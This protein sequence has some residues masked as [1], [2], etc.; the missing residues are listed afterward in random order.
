MRRPAYLAAGLVALALGFIGIFLPLLPTTP[1]V[2]LAAFCFARGNPAWEARLLADP[3]FG[4]SIRAWRER[5]AIPRNGKRLAVLM[6]L[7]SA[8]G[9]WFLLTPPWHVVPA[10]VCLVVG[11]WVLT[12]PSA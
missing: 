7:I 10:G 3:R 9:G 12:R 4:P 11:A 6:M 2:L 5:G 1:F 8:L